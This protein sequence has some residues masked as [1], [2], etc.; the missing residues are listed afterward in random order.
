MAEGHF[1]IYFFNTV[2]VSLV[3][4]FLTIVVKVMSGYAFAKYHFKGGQNLF[5]IVLATLMVPL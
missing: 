1:G 5:G 3:A 4:T 2:F